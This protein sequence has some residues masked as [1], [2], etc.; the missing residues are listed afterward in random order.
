MTITNPSDFIKPNLKNLEPKIVLYINYLEKENLK[1]Q[2]EIAKLQVANLSISNKI[3]AMEKEISGLTKR[4]NSATI[5]LPY[6]IGGPL[7]THVK[8]AGDK[9]IEI[10]YEH[11]K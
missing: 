7:P 1:L 4:T 2:S 8:T 3:K 11:D 5:L 6:K 9:L 10:F